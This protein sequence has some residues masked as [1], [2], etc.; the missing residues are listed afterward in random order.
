[1]NLDRIFEGAINEVSSVKRV[2]KEE[3]QYKIIV[4]DGNGVEEFLFRH[5][6]YNALRNELKK[7]YG[8][9]V[10]ERIISRVKKG[11]TNREFSDD[12]VDFEV[13][14]N[15]VK[16]V[17]S[18]LAEVN[19]MRKCSKSGKLYKVKSFGDKES[20]KDFI[21]KS[22]ESGKSYFLE[23][24]FEFGPGKVWVMVGGKAIKPEDAPPSMRATL[25][26]VLAYVKSNGLLATL[27]KEDKMP[28]D[29]TVKADGSAVITDDKGNVLKRFKV[30]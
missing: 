6:R 13:D 7:Y 27:S 2:T 5:H 22:K 26:R 10:V 17:E 24:D 18:V 9:K 20:A 11:E 14:G 19:V 28:A 8:D 21:E 16:I 30:N 1:M 15:K 3:G 29:V 4:K 12:K 25:Q 23:S